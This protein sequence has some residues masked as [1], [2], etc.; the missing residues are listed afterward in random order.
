MTK[1]ST[2]IRMVGLDLDGTLLTSE[3]ELTEHTRQVLTEAIRRGVVVLPATGRPLTGIPEEGPAF[4][5]HPLR[6]GVQRLPDR[7][8]EGG[9]GACRAAPPL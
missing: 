9:E 5:G 7:R 6:S 8:Y 3:K 2:R 4:S 1:C